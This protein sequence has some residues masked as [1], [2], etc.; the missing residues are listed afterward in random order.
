ME[1]EAGD[2]ATTAGPE[3]EESIEAVLLREIRERRRSWAEVKAETGFDGRRVILDEVMASLKVRRPAPKAKGKRTKAPTLAE[4]QN[5]A[6]AK[7]S[8]KGFK[9]ILDADGTAKYAAV[10][11]DLEAKDRAFE[12]DCAK[13]DFQ[14]KNPTGR[15][16]SARL[17]A[18]GSLQFDMWEGKSDDELD[19]A[20][21]A[22]R[23]EAARLEAAL[24]ELGAG[25]A[26]E[27]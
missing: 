7:D 18:D 1:I 12:L 13:L 22:E 23:R 27:D 14:R 25:E 2:A 9:D 8:G 17:N 24:I 15:G 16:M 5:L 20:I 26:A 21:E 19:A 4:L 3:V 11:E 10:L 6:A